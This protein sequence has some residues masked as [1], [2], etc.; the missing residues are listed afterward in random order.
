MCKIQYCFLLPKGMVVELRSWNHPDPLTN[1]YDGQAQ[2]FS[3]AFEILRQGI[4]ESAFPGAGFAVTQGN[5]LV[6]LAG[7]GHF[8]YDAGSEPVEPDTIYDLASVTKAIAT[9]TAAMILYEKRKLRLDM[10]V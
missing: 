3:R 10:P 9:T 8:T 2:S 6:A 5:D 1:A 4:A 7:V